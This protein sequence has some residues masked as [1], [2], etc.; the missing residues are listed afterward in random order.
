MPLRIFMNYVIVKVRAGE[1]T[2]KYIGS[3]D[4]Q[5]SS[6]VAVMAQLGR[7]ETEFIIYGSAV[8]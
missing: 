6:A 7:F 2:M 8:Q 3:R 1:N 4:M 5:A